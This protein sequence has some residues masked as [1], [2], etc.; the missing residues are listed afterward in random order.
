MFMCLAVCTLLAV[1]GI[2]LGVLSMY[3]GTAFI[4][5][6]QLVLIKESNLMGGTPSLDQLRDIVCFEITDGAR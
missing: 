3:P 6:L 2:N 1:E 5:V 4:G